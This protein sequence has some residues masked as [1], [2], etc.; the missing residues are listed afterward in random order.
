MPISQLAQSKLTKL[1]ELG[2][3]LIR[4]DVERDPNE[5]ECLMV[6][7]PTCSAVREEICQIRNIFSTTHAVSFIHDERRQLAKA[8]INS[9]Q[10]YDKAL[11]IQYAFLGVCA[12]VA[13]N[14]VKV[15]GK[16]HTP[17]E[18]MSF[19]C[20]DAI[21]ELTEAGYFKK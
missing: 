1:Q 13:A 14:S 2:F 10:N 8:R 3:K 7:C 6:G 12:S 15:L 11:I 17:D 21:K 18:I 4:N 20:G 19:F 16:A 5:A 9:L